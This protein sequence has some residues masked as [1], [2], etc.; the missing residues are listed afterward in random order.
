MGVAMRGDDGISGSL[1]S[2]IDL[3]QRA[4][5]DHLLRV[6]REIANTAL[7]I[8]SRDFAALL[9]D[10]ATVYC[11]ALRA[12]LLQRSNRCARSAS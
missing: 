6:I 7:D 2:Y 1:L 8:L 5:V 11:P 10:G 4:R 9:G 12:M 3:K